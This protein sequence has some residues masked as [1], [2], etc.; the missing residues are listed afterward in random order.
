ME[1]RDSE[2]DVFLGDCLQ[3]ILRADGDR[4]FAVE[5]YE[6]V[7]F[8][9]EHYLQKIDENGLFNVKGWNL[10]DWSPI[11]QPNEGV[12]THQN[13]FLAQTLRVA[14]EM[15]ELAGDSEGA[16]RYREA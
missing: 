5:M 8:T 7:R 4:A 15:G 1:Q 2:L 3:G 10:L 12:V 11:D 9:I 14:A 13:L 16:A 6:H